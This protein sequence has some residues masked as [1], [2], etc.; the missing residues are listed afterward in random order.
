MDVNFEQSKKKKQK[1]QFVNTHLESFLAATR[2][3]QATELVSETGP[4]SP[5]LPIILLGD[6]NS[7]PADPPPDSTAYNT[8]VGDQYDAAWRL[9]R[10]RP[11]GEHVLLVR[12]AVR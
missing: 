6:L 2:N 3:S 11:R 7:D 8:I 1:F 12:D 4:L 5:S 9:R 10:P